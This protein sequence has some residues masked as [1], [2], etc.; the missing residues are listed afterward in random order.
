MLSGFTEIASRSS[1]L[2]VCSL[3]DELYQRFDA[4]IE[5]Y[6]QLYKVETIGVS[7]AAGRGG[8]IGKRESWKGREG[9]QGK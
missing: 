4:A 6:P 3:L 8:G 5:E 2:E 1:P 7:R 9:H